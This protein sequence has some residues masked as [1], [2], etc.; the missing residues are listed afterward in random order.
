MGQAARKSEAETEASKP[1]A[2]H[3]PAPCAEEAYIAECSRTLRLLCPACF[4]GDTFG[5]ALEE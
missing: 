4:G 2:S 1:S 3:H 5:R